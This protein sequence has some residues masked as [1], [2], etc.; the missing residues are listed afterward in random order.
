MRFYEG[1]P[2]TVYVGFTTGCHDDQDERIARRVL[3]ELMSVYKDA[4]VLYSFVL[5]RRSWCA[6]ARGDPGD[7]VEIVGGIISEESCNSPSLVV[8]MDK[9]PQDVVSLAVDVKNGRTDL[10]SVY[11]VA[12]EK[13]ILIIELGGSQDTLISFVSSVL[14]SVGLFDGEIKITS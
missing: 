11:R 9:A 13:D 7:I 5:G 8:I 3:S 6:V 1:E 2:P 12:E 10:D 4:L 14:C